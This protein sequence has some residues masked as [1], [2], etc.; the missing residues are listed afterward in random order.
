M[1]PLTLIPARFAPHLLGL[2]RIV[3]ALLLIPHGT[4]KLFGVPHMEMFAGVKLMSQLGAAGVI[5]IVGGALLLVGFQTRLVAF[6]LSGFMA[7]AY[8]LGHAG[9][10]RCRWSTRA[11]SPSS[12]ASSSS[13][14]RSWALENSRSTK[15]D[16]QTQ[17]GVRIGRGAS[18]RSA[19]TSALHGRLSV[20]L[21]SPCASVARVVHASLLDRLQHLAEIVGLW[22]LQRRKLLV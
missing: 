8:F 4:A 13:I 6:V 22:R 11:N 14:S 18:S 3:L 7:F 16:H 19:K 1:K 15:V 12:I 2:L 10:G 17:D 20:A 21:S 5:E 9:R